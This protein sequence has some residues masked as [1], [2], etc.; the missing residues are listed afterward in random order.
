[1]VENLKKYM[2]EDEKRQIDGILEKATERMGKKQDVGQNTQF[3]YLKCQCECAE[4]LMHQNRDEKGQVDMEEDIQTLLKQI[5]EFCKKNGGCY[6]DE[7]ME[8]WREN[9]LPF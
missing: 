5:C 1:M 4:A 7:Q 6:W 9:E 8:K 3:L 2:T